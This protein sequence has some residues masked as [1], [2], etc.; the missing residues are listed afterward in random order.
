MV[1]GAHDQH[2]HHVAVNSQ[3]TGR[4]RRHLSDQIVNTFN[5]NINNSTSTMTALAAVVVVGVVKRTTTTQHLWRRETCV[6]MRMVW[7][8]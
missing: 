6:R 1:S 8:Y 3:A 2:Y 7:H 4:L 5:S